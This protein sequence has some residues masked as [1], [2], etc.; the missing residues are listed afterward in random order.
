[1]SVAPR[2]A[3]AQSDWARLFQAAFKQSRNPMLLLDSHRRQVD[4][5]GA[6]VKLL[7]Y[8]RDQIIGR[9]IYEFRA[10]DKVERRKWEALM[11]KGHFTG[12]AELL[13]ADGDSVAVQWAATVEIVTGHRQILFVALNT[14][15]WGARFRR[16]VPPDAAPGKLSDRELTVVRLVADGNTGPE[17]ADELRIAHDT[18]RTHVRN[19][20]AKVGA[21][22][23]AHLVAKA[24][25]EGHALN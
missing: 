9:P 20:M 19:A 22:S 13:C 18:V 7:G 4:A 3:A 23:R 24:L 12:D 1:M 6:Y 17:I 16:S 10:G 14:S 25:A 15:R 21:R 5:N 8:P 2:A 11:S